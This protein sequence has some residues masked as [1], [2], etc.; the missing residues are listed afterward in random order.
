VGDRIERWMMD[1]TRRFLERAFERTQVDCYPR[2]SGAALLFR[3][4]GQTPTGHRRLLHQLWID[5]SFFTRCA[6]RS[7]LRS[8]LEGADVVTSLKKAGDKIVELH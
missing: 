7:A 8:A 6:E 1:E 3:L 5:R 4:E 2:E